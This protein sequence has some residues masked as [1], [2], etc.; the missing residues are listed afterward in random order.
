MSD[1]HDRERGLILC[2]VVQ[3]LLEI[4]N[5]RPHVS[6]MQLEAAERIRKHLGAIADMVKEDE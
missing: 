1:I 4:D 5:L 6:L 3:A 2:E